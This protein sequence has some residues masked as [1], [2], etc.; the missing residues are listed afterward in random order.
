M[1]FPIWGFGPDLPLTR[2]TYTM[3]FMYEKQPREVFFKERCFEK[4]CKIHR[5]IPVPASFLIKL[6]LRVNASDLWECFSLT[7]LK[8]FNYM[9]TYRYTNGELKICQY[10]RLCMKIIFSRFYIK[11]PFTFW[12]LRTWDMWKVCL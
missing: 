5:K 1:V 12:V 7:V 10:L 6:Y 3:D 4:F 11:T 8:V 2:T 9:I